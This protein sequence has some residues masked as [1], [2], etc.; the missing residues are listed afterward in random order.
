VVVWK[1]AQSVR[2]IEASGV[3]ALP[4]H[5]KDSSAH[6]LYSAAVIIFYFF[7]IASPAEESGRIDSAKA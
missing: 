4:G 6:A 5:F 2:P 1:G 7:H 3:V